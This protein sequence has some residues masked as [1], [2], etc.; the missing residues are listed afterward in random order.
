MAAFSQI[1]SGTMKKGTYI[2]D[3]CPYCQTSYSATFTGKFSIFECYECKKVQTYEQFISELSRDILYSESIAT[4][5]A[6]KEPEGLKDVAG[7]IDSTIGIFTIPSGFNSLDMMTGGFKSGEMTIISGKRSEGKS[8]FCGQLALNA[9][10]NGK[11][12]FFYSGELSEIAFKNWVFLQAAGQNYLDSYYDQFGALR[13]IIDKQYAEPR[14]RSWLKGKM[15]LYDNKVIKTSEVNTIVERAKVAYE[16][17][18]SDLFFIDNLKTARFKK[19][20]ERDYYRKQANFVG[21]ML[22][23]AQNNNVHV[24]IVVHPKKEDSGDDNDNVSGLSDITDIAHYVMTMKRL[25]DEQ[26]EQQ[27][28]SAI[29]DLSKNRTYGE[30]GRLK[31]DF[32]IPSKRFIMQNSKNVEKYSWEDEV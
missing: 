27:G 28:C 11:N 20:N 5:Q 6:P 24:V 22:A 23:F 29:L 8:T 1:F 2:L 16:Y 30:V 15:V 4:L 13:Y 32:D 21:D 12:V 14:I 7:I 10:E 31:M 3:E 26:A 9:V 17:Y 19:D 25:S 18:G